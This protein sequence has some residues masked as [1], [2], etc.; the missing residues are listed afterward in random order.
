M[1]QILFLIRKELKQKSDPRIKKQYQRFFKEKIKT[2]GVKTPAVREISKK[3]FREIKNLAKKRIFSLC[4]ELFKSG[5]NE[6]IAIAFDWVY[7]TKKQLTKSDFPI[8]ER[9]LKKYIANWGTCDDFST[10]ALGYF[11]FQYP[12]FLKKTEVWARSENRWLRRASA[13][14]LIYSLRR[15]RALEQVFRIADILLQDEDDLVRKG[16]GWMLKEA[17]NIY[18]KEVFEYVMRNKDKMPRTALRYAI[19]KMPGEMKRRA[20]RGERSQPD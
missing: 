5:Y 18:R 11:L 9:W 1:R 8:F 4:E 12:E 16:Y 7:R 2:Y 13:V 19:E 10:H 3:Y 17:S 20:T 14:S 6:E 15:G